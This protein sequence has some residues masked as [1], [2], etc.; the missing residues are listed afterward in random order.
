MAGKR[1]ISDFKRDFLARVAY[2]RIKSKYP[3]QQL[4]ADAMGIDQPKYST[5]EARSMLPHALVPQFCQL[6]EVTIPWLYTG[7]VTTEMLRVIEE[8]SRPRKHKRRKAA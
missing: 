4:M 2:A 6:C 5:Y 8:N 1:T 7:A 3:T